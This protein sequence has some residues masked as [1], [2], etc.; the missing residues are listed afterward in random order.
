MIN[1]MNYGIIETE[2][3]KKESILS[4]FNVLKS[5]LIRPIESTNNEVWHTNLILIDDKGIINTIQTIEKN[6]KDE[7]FGAVFNQKYY[8]LIFRNKTFELSAVKDVESDIYKEAQKYAI[9]HGVQAIYTNFYDN[10][11]EYISFISE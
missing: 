4:D 10:L 8:F 5:R 1:L 3:L 11:T 2:S 7:W 6:M 9:D